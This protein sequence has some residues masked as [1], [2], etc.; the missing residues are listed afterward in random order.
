MQAVQATYTFRV[1]DV[2]TSPAPAPNAANL[3]DELNALG[4][5]GFG[6]AAVLND[7]DR[8]VLMRQTGIRTVELEEPRILSARPAAAATR[9][10]PVDRSRR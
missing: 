4:A 7:G 5:E 8:L 6:I 1:L 9:E 3:E 10:F 2:G